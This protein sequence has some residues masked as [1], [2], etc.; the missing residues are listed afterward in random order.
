MNSFS[1]WMTVDRSIM[2]SN[3]RTEQKNDE[4][5]LQ[6]AAHPFEVLYQLSA[7]DYDSTN[8]ASKVKI[9]VI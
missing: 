8:Q 6:P 7:V 2:K 3:L 9:S 4:F 1:E 5:K